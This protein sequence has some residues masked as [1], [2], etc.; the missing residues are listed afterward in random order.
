M[1]AHNDQEESSAPSVGRKV[2]ETGKDFAKSMA[3]KAL[4]EIAKKLV[5]MLAKIIMKLIAK[6][7]A[8]ALIYLGVPALIIG[9]LVIIVGGG[10]IYASISFGWLSD[11]DNGQLAQKLRNQYESAVVRTTDLPEY[12]PPTLVVQSIDNIRITINNLENTDIDPNP[13]AS[14]LKPDLTYQK[15]TNT[16]TTV[17]RHT[18]TVTID[19]G[20]GESHTE[21][22]EYTTTSTSEEIVKLLVK[23]H[24]WNRIEIITYH[25]ETTTESS[26]DT[27]V[28]KTF[29]VR[30]AQGCSMPST[31]TGSASGGTVNGQPSGK[32]HPLFILYGPAATE[33]ERKS[34]IP[35]AITL[36][37]L[38]QE[39]GWQPSELASKYYNFFGIK[40]QN[41]DGW[42]GPVVSYQTKEQDKY[43]NEYTINANFRVYANAT[44]GFHGHSKFLLDNGRYKPVLSQKNPYS[45]A[46]GLQAAGYATDVNYSYNLRSLIHEYNLTQYDLDKGIDSA[47]G[48][49]YEDVGYSG[50]IGDTTGG[51]SPGCGTPDFTKFD[52]ILK[53]LN[54]GTDDAAM[55]MLSINENDPGHSL[56]SSYNGFY[57]D[58]FKMLNASGSYGGGGS[59]GGSIADAPVI[60]G[61]NTWIFPTLTKAILGSPYGWRYDDTKGKEALHKGQDISRTPDDRNNNVS[62][63]IYAVE[64]G[65]IEGAGDRNDGYGYSVLIN[66][67]NGIRTRYS[68]MVAGSLQVKAGDQVKKGK[69][70]GIMGQ[71]GLSNGVHLHFE[72]L[73]GESNTP[74]NPIGYLHK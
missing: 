65:V 18:E 51:L 72:V 64:D 40:A 49:P 45:F 58:A 43:G 59:S 10:I 36:A 53:K 1:A 66:H 2:L 52:A 57:Q 28:T 44:E 14:A 73:V 3:K 56:I 32:S 34:G 22:R 12:R 13:I 62:Y 16:T 6:V 68:H 67:G 8:G 69:S 38:V 60:P 26:G 71:T 50:P 37:Q 55:A 46:N 70:L 24:A 23:A 39:S 35:A 27:T 5:K 7:I 41:G 29:W 19:D 48:Q 21:E 33:E 11:D 61:S 4:K 54:F 74:V 25:Q 31:S 20:D 17:T 9:L 47:T 30:D 42:T 63:P 15:F